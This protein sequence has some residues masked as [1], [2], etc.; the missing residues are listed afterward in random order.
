MTLEAA[1]VSTVE[2]S[3]IALSVTF[4]SPEL[5][6]DPPDEPL[7]AGVGTRTRA[8]EAYEVGRDNMTI[9]GIKAPT[10]TQTATTNRRRR[11]SQSTRPIS[12]VAQTIERPPR[13]RDRGPCT[14]Q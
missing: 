8:V 2:L 3:A 6:L 1:A 9:V 13:R 10:R 5:P 4:V 11:K 7:L 14:P 12:N